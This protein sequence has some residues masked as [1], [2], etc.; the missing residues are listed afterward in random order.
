MRIL[1][2]SSEIA[3]FAKIGGLGD[4]GGSLPKAL[5]KMGH[6]VR[7][8]MPAYRVIEE[9]VR[10]GQDDIRPLPGQ[11]LVPMGSGIYPAGIFEST[12]PGSDV[13]VYFIAEW[14][15]FDRDAVYGYWDDPHRFTF[16]SRASLELAR[17]LD[18][19]PD[20]LHAN[21]W[22]TGPAVTWLATTGQA[23]DYYRGIPSVFTIHNLAHQGISGWDILDYL[24]VITHGLVEERYGEVNF[25]ARGI[26]HAT[27]VNTVSP[28]YAK[29]IMTE[30]G[31]AGLERILRYRGEDV[32]G[33]LNGLDYQSWNPADDPR[34]AAAYSGDDMEGRLLNRRALQ[35][36]ANLPQRD[37]IPLLGMVTRLDWQKGLDITGHAFHLLLNGIAGEVQIVV[38]GTGVAHYEQMIAHLAHYHSSKM[39]GIL[40]YDPELAA[41][42]YA[43]SDM[44][45]MPSLFEPCGLGQLIAMKYGSVPVVRKTGGLADTVEDGETGFSF[46]E[47]TSGAFLNAIERAIYTYNTDEKSWRIIQQN[48]MKSDFSWDRSANGYVKL[49]QE[50]VARMG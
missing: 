37:D 29:E 18:W 3:P 43:G 44:F 38:L 14:N 34:I 6:D 7:V 23:E 4:V 50:A 26:Y 31:G 21:D 19:R 40:D 46:S 20:I 22:H 1:F 28:T 36:R 49:Y 25:M 41:L 10:S 5:K 45:L 13:P 35:A 9:S 30:E 15:M 11:L 32:R 2:I 48:G 27:L 39:A 12:L 16:F 47:Y 42:I 17:A 33:I 24:G 8:V